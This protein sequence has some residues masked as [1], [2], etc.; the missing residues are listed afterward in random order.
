MF[1]PPRSRETFLLVR[2]VV[3]LLRMQLLRQTCPCLYHFRFLERFCQ[4]RVHRL[5]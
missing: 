4:L 2:G 3:Q 1:A 5:D